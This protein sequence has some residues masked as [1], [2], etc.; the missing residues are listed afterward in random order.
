MNRHFQNDRSDRG[1]IS[2]FYRQQY[3]TNLSEV[4][5]L[6]N[7]PSGADRRGRHLYSS[8]GGQGGG[9]THQHQE[10]RVYIL[11]NSQNIIKFDNEL[12]QKCHQNRTN[13]H[14]C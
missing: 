6:A 8:G 3:F 5:D 4:D 9:D 7:P 12:F 1:T 11:L 2:W 10:V 14:L 13:L